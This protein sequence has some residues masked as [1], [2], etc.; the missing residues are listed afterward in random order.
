APA[1]S[2][3]VEAFFYFLFPALFAC[4]SGWS[5]KRALVCVVLAWPVSLVAPLCYELINPD[6]LG[7]TVVGFHR[8][9]LHQQTSGCLRVLIYA[10]LFPLPAF[11]LGIL[12]SHVLIGQ[13]RQPRISRRVG[14]AATAISAVGIA[15]LIAILYASDSRQYSFLHNG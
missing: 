11:V 4:I 12:L 5:R 7:R 8:T 9:Y 15:V 13:I 3:S 10:P 2:L 14:F 6:S 1:W